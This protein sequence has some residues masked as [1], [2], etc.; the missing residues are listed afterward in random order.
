MRIS[1]CQPSFVIFAAASQWKS[2]EESSPLLSS[3]T[4]SY[5]MPR[6]VARKRIA[7][8]ASPFVSRMIPA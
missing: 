8:F 3:V 7:F 2:G 6:G 4:A 1:S 5:W